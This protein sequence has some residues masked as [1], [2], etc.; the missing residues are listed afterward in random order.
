VTVIIPKVNTT[1][2]LDD[3]VDDDF[4]RPTDV[5][6]LFYEREIISWLPAFQHIINVL[7]AIEYLFTVTVTVTILLELG[8]ARGGAVAEKTC[9]LLRFHR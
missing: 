2:K 5:R 7:D 6:Q 9:R 4:M 8:R 3:C 1:V